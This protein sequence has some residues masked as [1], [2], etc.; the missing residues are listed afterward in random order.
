MSN[1]NKI[2]LSN[3][4]IFDL[5]RQDFFKNMTELFILPDFETTIEEIEETLLD[6]PT[7]IELDNLDGFV[8]QYDNYINL[9]S[10]ENVNLY[11]DEEEK[12]A[13][14]IKLQ[15]EELA[16]MVEQNTANIDYI[17]TMADIEL[18]WGTT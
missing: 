6:D 3:N 12:E 8:K 10:I 2:K 5:L 1:Y 17:A 14:A 9:I 16:P 7:F 13:Y 4:K 18:Q 15:E 11:D